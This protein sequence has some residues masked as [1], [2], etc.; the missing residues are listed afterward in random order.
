MKNI[1]KKLAALLARGIKKELI[2]SSVDTKG[3]SEEW[4]DG[5]F[6]KTVTTFKNGVSFISL[7]DSCPGFSRSTT[8]VIF[9]HITLYYRTFCEDAGNEYGNYKFKSLVSNVCYAYGAELR[10]V[11]ALIKESKAKMQQAST[12]TFVDRE[13]ANVKVSLKELKMEDVVVGK[14]Y[15]TKNRFSKNFV[16]GECVRVGDEIGFKYITLKKKRQFNC[17]CLV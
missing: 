12:D 9:K 16:V 11:Q 8:K 13:M 10:A 2:V 1:E 3:I 6:S 17:K 4:S 15:S 5:T 7:V 14:I